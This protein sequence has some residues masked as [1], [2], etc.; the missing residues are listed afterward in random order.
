VIVRADPALLPEIKQFGAFDIDA[1][2]NCGNCTAVCPLSKDDDAFPRRMIRYAQL[3]LAD[4]LVGSREVWL[5][6]YCGECTTTCPREADPGGFMASARRYTI[7]RLDP[8]PLSRWMYLYPGRA[9]A[10]M[11]ITAIAL[12]WALLFRSPGLPEGRFS[13]ARMLDYI[14]YDVIHWSGIFVMVFVGAMSLITVINLVWRL[15]HE[16][17]AIGAPKPDESPGPFPLRSGL[18]ALRV[19]LAEVFTHTSFR[20]C[21]DEE[22][23]KQPLHLRPWFVH[24]SIMAGF[25][26]LLAATTLDYAFKDPDAHVPIWAP[27]RLLGTLAGILFVYGTTVAIIRRFKQAD[28]STARSEF[29]DWVFLLFL[30]ATGVTGFV[31]EIAIYLDIAGGTFLYGFFLIHIVL[32]LELLLLLPFSKFA[33]SIYRPL[34]LLIHGFRRARLAN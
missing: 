18:A 26:G 34:A 9:V 11:L 3:G 2:F 25:F 15:T 21:G 19:A 32:A 13:T 17:R 8:T 10:V 4:H 7:S 24:F 20:T 22:E 29:S 1:C 30:W 28:H 33:H 5:C 23:E 27:I 16:S 14:P 31:I 12:M 6:H